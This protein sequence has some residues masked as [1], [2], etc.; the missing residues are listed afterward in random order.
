[1]NIKQRIL[2]G[3]IASRITALAGLAV[4]AAVPPSRA[5]DTIDTTGGITISA[6]TNIGA[7]VAATNVIGAGTLTLNGAGTV[8]LGNNGPNHLVNLNMTGGLID[9]QTGVNLQNGGWSDGVWTA[10]LASM[11]VASGATLDVWDGNAV[12]ID[13]LT[14]AGSVTISPAFGPGWAGNRSLVIG[15][16]NGGGTF[17]GNITGNSGNAD[18]GNLSLTKNGSGTEILTGANTYAGTTTVSGG[19]LQIGTGGNSGSLGTGNVTNNAALVFNR[20]DTYTVSNA[21]GGSGTVTVT[22]G[23]TAV[24]TNT[25]TYGGTTTVNGGILQLNVGNTSGTL[26]GDGAIVI[27]NGG[28]LSSGAIDGLGYFN[29]TARGR[30]FSDAVSRRC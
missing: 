9:V 1:M 29:H 3:S 16:N 5:D 17:S 26:A 11:N 27:N 2:T 22:G 28:T 21:I 12:R 4:L 8:G 6:P 10:N 20:S 18:G 30:I 7:N 24:F 23:G 14:G 25:K 13:A 15:V 19:T